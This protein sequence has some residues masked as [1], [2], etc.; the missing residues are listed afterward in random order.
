MKV[1]QH[2]KSTI[3]SCNLAGFHRWKI[4]PSFGARTTNGTDHVL[5]RARFRLITYKP[6]E[7][8]AKSVKRRCSGNTGRTQNAVYYDRIT[9]A[10]YHQYTNGLGLGGKPVDEA[11]NRNER[12][13]LEGS[14][15]DFK[16]TKDW[17][18]ATSVQLSLKEKK[19]ACWEA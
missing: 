7:A 2:I 8:I 3:S 19:L 18:S 10:Q 5:L 4:V 15:E 16:P 13:R 1:A 6:K 12:S 11:Q 9:V 14:R 17:M